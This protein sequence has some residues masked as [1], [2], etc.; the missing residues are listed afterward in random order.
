MK[1]LW[2]MIRKELIDNLRDRRS[3][4]FALLYGP[5]LL[6]LMMV[7]PLALG[8]KKYGID[9]D[10]AVS[11]HMVEPERYPN[12]VRYL[13]EQNI[14]IS[15]APEK[16]RLALKQ[17]QLK[18]F[19]ELEDDYEHALRSG[20][21]ADIKLY[22][23]G[24][25]SDSRKMLLKVRNALQSYQRQMSQLRLLARGLE[26]ELVAIV[27]VHQ[28]DLSQ[29]N[30]ANETMS[31][32]LPMVLVL[33]MAMG[34]FYF[35]VDTSAGEKERHSL[36][37]LL[38]LNVLRYR[39]VLAKLVAVMSFVGLSCFLTT[40]SIFLVFYFLPVESLRSLLDI[41]AWYFVKAFAYA[42][43][44]IPLFSALML[45]IS[46]NARNI[47]EAQTH[48]GL[49]MMLPML[50]FFI[51]TFMEPEPSLG[52]Y[53][54]PILSQYLLLDHAM[55]AKSVALQEVVLASASALALAAAL[56]AYIV[57]LYK[58]ETLLK[59]S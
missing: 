26:P 2:A 21:T 13:R 38:S 10:R 48:L 27:Q 7:G 51:L 59:N 34:G 53:S 50:P 40:I 33:A 28:Y 43:P 32:I 42:S 31:H 25:A 52:L 58:Q 29:V 39:L 55:N 44:L 1:Q 24:D 16:P 17:K 20:Q 3:M 23:L 49:M 6:P 36:E 18:L 35:A 9:I 11:V 30:E 46:A 19:I 12:L 54:I 4:F 15:P 47:K 5:V 8:A 57:R 45:L 22:Y 56:A 37:P 14:D 41:R